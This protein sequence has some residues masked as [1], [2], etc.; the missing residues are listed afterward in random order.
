MESPPSTTQP[1]TMIFPSAVLD[2]LRTM[3]RIVPLLSVCKASRM[4]FQY[5]VENWFRVNMDLFRGNPKRL[6]RVRISDINQLCHINNI[7][8][9]LFDDTDIPNHPIDKLPPTITH[10][11]LGH[12]FNK[13]VDHLPPL[14]TH[15]T[16]NYWFDQPV[17]KLPPLL[18]HLEFDDEF[19]QCVDRLPPLLTHLK[20]GFSFNQRVDHLPSSLMYLE[21]GD[22][23]DQPVDG[24]PPL[25]THLKFG[26]SFNY[27][28]DKLPQSLIRLTFGYEFNQD[29]DKLPSGI[30]TLV[31]YRK[32]SRGLLELMDKY[33]KQFPEKPGS[34]FSFII[35]H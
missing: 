1:L 5:Y 26:N 31:I 12:D 28:V 13:N 20:F 16:F 33:S 25:L 11:T 6:K 17:D 23:F 30:K 19:N 32:Y 35:H 21:F 18:T 3:I 14:L 2:V 7:I 34:N 4:D 29:I 22:N 15:L 24:L 9:V 8:D 10:L 27:C